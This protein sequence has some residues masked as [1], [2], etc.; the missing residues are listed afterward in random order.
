MSKNKNKTQ[1]NVE[2]PKVEIKEVTATAV[3]TDVELSEFVVAEKK[4][5]TSKK[6]VIGA[7]EPALEKFWGASVFEEL[8][9]KKLVVKR[10]K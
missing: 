5:I 7:G 8:K 1:P 10:E 9:K 6:G 3:K 2:A 4:S